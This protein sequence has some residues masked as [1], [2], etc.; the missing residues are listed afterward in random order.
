M[1]PQ[2]TQPERDQHQG[3]GQRVGLR[4]G[5]AQV[6]ETD[7]GGHRQQQPAR[8]R[9]QPAVRV[10]Q[11]R[12]GHEGAGDRQIEGEHDEPARLRHG[13][14]VGHRS[15]SRRHSRDSGRHL[16]GGPW[17]QQGREAEHHQC[18]RGPP[19]GVQ[20]AEL[21]DRPDQCCGD[22]RT[23]AQADGPDLG[24]RG[25]HRHG[26][27]RNE[28]QGQR[29]R[30]EHD[31]RQADR[32]RGGEDE[33]RQ[34]CP[35]IA[36]PPLGAQRPPPEGQPD[37]EQCGDDRGQGDRVR[38]GGRHPGQQDECEGRR[39][40]VHQ[41]L[42]RG[43]Q[44][45]HGDQAADRGRRGQQRGMQRGDG[46][47]ESHG[48]RARPGLADPEHGLQHDRGGGRGQDRR[49]QEGD[50]HRQQ[51][52]DPPRGGDGQGD[53]REG[54]RRQQGG[55]GRLRGRVVEHRCQQGRHGEGRGDPGDGGG[56]QGEG[57]GGCCRTG[58]DEGGGED[59]PR[60]EPTPEV[61][62]VGVLDQADHPG[63]CQRAPPQGGAGTEEP[64]EK[65]HPRGVRRGGEGGQRE[66]AHS[67]HSAVVQGQVQRAHGRDPES[68]RPD[69]LGGPERAMRADR[70]GHQ[71]SD[72]AERQPDGEHETAIGD[73]EP[74]RVGRAHQVEDQETGGDHAE[75]LGRGPEP[76]PPSPGGKRAGGDG[77]SDEDGGAAADP[78]ELPRDGQEGDRRHQEAQGAQGEQDPRH[79][80]TAQ[81]APLG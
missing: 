43:A 66:R 68:Q 22:D 36:R 37:D 79:R 51:P 15:E 23:D 30:G 1:T 32:E 9:E 61:A 33:R 12:C 57:L 80:G 20:V 16:D 44:E 50:G 14:P 62:G 55:G 6:V 54:Q 18:R 29:D 34:G 19:S 71:E 13:E 26:G 31:A 65:P 27:G 7:P 21:G 67:E 38:R 75:G 10:C 17:Q 39:G 8:D 35:E 64:G 3:R 74:A 52:G 78:E 56:R 40:A 76:A 25:Q 42:P 60:V 58:S 11:R 53:D 59:R 48:S 46:L 28:G 77:E 41:R 69:H 4:G 49:H 72:G 81:S 47:G 45:R 5:D 70:V 24:T 2:V 73:A 63:E